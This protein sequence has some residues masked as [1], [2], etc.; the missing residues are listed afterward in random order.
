MNGLPKRYS[1]MTDPAKPRVAVLFDHLESDYHVEVLAGVLRAARARAKVLVVPGGWL[2]RSDAEPIARNSIYDLLP[3]ARVDGVIALAGS[4]SNYAGLG[5]F[6]ELLSRFTHVPI[7][8]IGIDLADTPSVWVDNGIGIDA[9]VSHLVTVHGKRRIAFVRGPEA[10]TEAE[11]RRRAFRRALDQHGIPE[12][13]RLVVPGS[14]EREDGI[15]AMRELFD[16]RRFTPATLDAIAAVN[17]ETALGA[18]DELTRR[19]IGVPQQIAIVGFDDALSARTANPP[20]TTVNQR[21]ELQAFTATQELLNAIA[22]KRAPAGKKLDPE[23]VVRASC[24]CNVRLQNDSTEVRS[25]P[26][27]ARSA[28]LV[29]VER[30]AMVAADL[31]RAAAGRLVGM[32]GWEGRLLDALTQDLRDPRGQNFVYEVELFARKNVAFG[33]SIMIC[34]DVLTALRLQAVAATSVEPS[35]RPRLEDLLQ[36]ARFRLARISTDVDHE[37]HQS[38]NLH[39]RIV[40]KACLSVI[41]GD[42]PRVLGAAL[43]EHL[44]AL[45]ISACTLTE[46][47]TKRTSSELVIVARFA[48]NSLSSPLRALPLRDLGIDSGLEREDVLV[49]E[50]LEFAGQPVGIAAFAWGARNPVHYEVLREVL[51]AAVHSLLKQK[52]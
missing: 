18:L 37:R 32:S 16:A 41:A 10:S 23:L 47:H 30:R 45:G 26:T 2:S 1:T 3:A 20:L 19:G 34:H 29:L 43:S 15:A 6:R 11:E 39:A 44:P 49:L 24:G 13:D 7:V 38:L 52:P 14:F 9:V 28:A 40:T 48:S 50:P 8:A 33:R 5:R 46:L 17:D 21:V 51:S 25:T 36:E 22:A 12:D 4:L 42:D 27:M 35:A 31:A